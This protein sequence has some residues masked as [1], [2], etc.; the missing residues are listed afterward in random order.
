V[1]PETEEKKDRNTLST[2]HRTTA[3]NI[4]VTTLQHPH[5]SLEIQV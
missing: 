5:H 4:P 1:L 2:K 3:A